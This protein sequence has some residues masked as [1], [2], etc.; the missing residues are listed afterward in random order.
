M[1]FL[2]LELETKALA[3]P[4][5]AAGPRISRAFLEIS[6]GFSRFLEDFS[7]ILEDSRGFL[8]VFRIL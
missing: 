7:R 4:P 6:R 3:L 5:R 2:G 1:S 8:E